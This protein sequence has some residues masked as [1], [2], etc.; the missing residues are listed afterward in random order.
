MT[1][2]MTANQIGKFYVLLNG[3]NDIAY[4]GFLTLQFL[5]LEP[6]LRALLPEAQAS[7]SIGLTMTLIALQLLFQIL[8]EGPTGAIADMYGRARAVA[9]SF[10]C[11]LVAI[12]LVIVCVLVDLRSDSPALALSAVIGALILAQVLTATGEAF[13]EGSIEAWLCDECKIA[14]PENHK[15]IINKTFE[16]SALAQNIAILLAVTIVLVAWQASGKPGG[17]ALAALAGGLCLAGAVI[18]HRLSA[19]EAFIGRAAEVTVLESS[20][21]CLSA[22]KTIKSKLSAAFMVAFRSDKVSVRRL[23]VVLVLPFPCWIMLSW[24]YTSFVQS[25]GSGDTTSLPASYL[26]WL[27]ITLGVARVLGAWVGK[28]LGRYTDEESLQAVFEKAVLVNVSFLFGAAMLLVLRPL[29]ESSFYSSIGIALFLSSV[30]MAKGSEEVIKLSKNKFLASALPNGEIRATT[31]SFVSVAQ[32]AFG[33]V[34]ISL[35]GLLAFTVTDS[36][37]RQPVIIFAVCASTGIAGW[38]IYFGGKRLSG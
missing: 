35:S 20:P 19:R 17:I 18:S 2:K 23:I 10:W 25:S 8:A 28:W 26:L 34:A 1:T 36:N 6:T 32:N 29:V 13:L 15:E 31:L 33:F 30:A 12:I 21:E 37:I 7:M 22:D 9:M 3:I 27:G 5:L 16:Y 4:F 24:F 38:L 14:D 11:R